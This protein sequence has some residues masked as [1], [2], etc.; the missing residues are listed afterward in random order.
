MSVDDRQDDGTGVHRASP[1]GP[2]VA[3]PRQAPGGTT[4]R[5]PPPRPASPPRVK[6]ASL[7]SAFRPSFW[8]V[9]IF[10]LLSSGVGIRA[11]RDLSRPGAF[12]Y[13]RETYVSA[14]MRSSVIPDAGIDGSGHGRRTLAI[15][16]RIGA[17]SASWFRE[18]LDEAHLSAGDAVL[19]SSQGGALNQAAIMGEV[20]RAHGLVTAVGTADASG[21]IRPAYCASACVLVF[22]GGKTRYGIE[23]SELGVHRFTTNTPAGDPVAEA[24][25]VSGA[26][27]GYM[28]RMGVSSTIVEAMSQTSEIRWLSPKEALAMNLVTTPVTRP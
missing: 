25:R 13:W 18:R 15:S 1:T 23:G 27:L 22:A 26:V 11:Y 24:Q 2:R 7:R 14:S 28:T 6:T 16:G 10:V 12:D 8:S 3:P 21:R 5:Q 4:P 17:A 19:L 9:V 20:I